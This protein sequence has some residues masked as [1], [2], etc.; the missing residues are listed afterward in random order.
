MATPNARRE[1]RSLAELATKKLCR[2]RI[3][4]RFS[5]FDSDFRHNL[6]IIPIVSARPN[7]S[8]RSKS[9]RAKLFPN[10]T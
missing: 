9:R 10:L 5:D 4:L 2:E 1:H 6:L 7:S 3:K 8:S